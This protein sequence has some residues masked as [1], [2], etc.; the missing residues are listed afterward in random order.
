MPDPDPTKLTIPKGAADDP[1]PWT[2]PAGAVQAQTVGGQER[3]VLGTGG[4]ASRVIGDLL[5][6]LEPPLA[7]LYVLHTP[8]GEGEEGRYQS[9]KLDAA[10]V[11][12]ILA[13]YAPLI[14]S[15]ARHDFWVHSLANNN[16]LVVDRHDVIYAYGDELSAAIGS[17]FDPPSAM[18]ALGTH[19]DRHMHHYRAEFDALSVALLAEFDWWRTELQED[20]LQN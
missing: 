19:M 10:E 18:T 2:T 11:R 9:P 7:I 12:R 15:D 3:L 17:R 16:T 20:D 5:P 1:V 6:V 14:D 13:A 4:R 8:R